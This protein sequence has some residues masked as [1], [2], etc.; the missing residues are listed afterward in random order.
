MTQR[1]FSGKGRKREYQLTTAKLTEKRSKSK[2][3]HPKERNNLITTNRSKKVRTSEKVQ[4]RRKKTRG[5]STKRER[6]EK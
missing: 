3:P 6:V 1:H 4:K 2:T 5:C